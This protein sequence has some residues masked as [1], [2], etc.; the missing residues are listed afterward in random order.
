MVKADIFIVDDN[1]DNINVLE[2]ILKEHQYKVRKASSAIRALTAIRTAP[3]DLVLLDISMPEMSGYEVCQQLKE[4]S[5]TSKIPVIFISAMDDVLDKVKAFKVGATDYISKPFQVE[6]VLVRVENQL[7]IHFLRKELEEK[8]QLLEHQYQELQKEK[9]ALLEEQKRT[10]KVF[11]TLVELLPGL[12][13]DKKYR[14][15]K[16]IGKGGFGAVYRAVHL[17][18]QNL[19]AIKIFRPFTGSQSSQ[20]LERFR[21]E[22]ISACRV[23]HPNVVTILDFGVSDNGIAYLVMEL[24]EGHTLAT[25]MS[26]KPI[27]SPLRCAEIIVPICKVLSKAHQLGIVHR[28]IKPD[29][30]FLHKSQKGEMVKVV[31]FGIAKLVSEVEG[32]SQDSLT[33]TGHFIGTP[34]YMAPER[35]ENLPYNGQ[36]DVYSLGVIAYQMLCGSLPFLS[37]PTNFFSII[38][39]FLTQEP[40]PLRKLNPEISSPLEE[41]I[42]STL[43]KDPKKRPTPN[44]FAEQM[45]LLLGIDS[46][47]LSLDEPL[48]ESLNESL[49][50]Y[51]ETP[52]QITPA[53]ITN[54]VK[55]D[56]IND[57]TMAEF[58]D[59]QSITQILNEWNNGEK[60]ALDKLLP[61]V[62]TELH[63]IAASYIRKERMDHTLQ[64][65]A[66]INETYIQ[67]VESELEWENRKH[68]LAS[69]ACIMRRILVNYAIA[70]NSAKRGG[71][72]YKIPIEDISYLSEQQDWDLIAL[73]EALNKL[74]EINPRQAQIIEL[75]FFGGF[76]SEQIAK[77]L[78]ISDA[79]VRRE[80]TA[81]KVWLK[82]LL[83]KESK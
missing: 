56:F 1:I 17:N 26:Q 43:A 34:N 63:K 55:P 51:A 10:D 30:I 60:L 33:Q 69:A 73:E 74:L 2:K 76:T 46:S 71:S 7:T 36:A 13:L 12:I 53:S 54:G 31:D 68:F 20:A 49:S 29:N 35:F 42:M 15:E 79:T 57:N 80:L 18:L 40:I 21:L 58:L 9:D 39:T 65:T 44:Q 72:F 78:S 50:E 52:N 4:Y 24:L 23:N 6:E 83:S 45:L 37:E 27:F 38:K 82:D 11:S 75:N 70:H 25:E 66:L 22:G 3:P 67:M 59:N 5:V 16:K 61:L 8:N 62:Y 41:L 81:A 28:D 14:L 32:F 47:Q 48:N 19:V 64:S 77:L